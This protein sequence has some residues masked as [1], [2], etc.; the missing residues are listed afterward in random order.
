MATSSTLTK[1]GITWNF[2]NEISYGTYNN[3]DYWVVGPVLVSSISPAFDSRLDGS[4]KNGSM[5]ASVLSLTSQG[6]DE[7]ATFAVPYTSS[8]NA[9]CYIGQ[10][11]PLVV[12][13][14]DRLISVASKDVFPPIDSVGI[15]TCVSSVVDGDHFRPGYTDFTRDYIN[16]SGY[17][18]SIVSRL[19][20]LDI[21][22]ILTKAEPVVSS[23]I[24]SLSSSWFD[25]FIGPNSKLLRPYSLMPHEDT[26]LAAKIS[27]AAA[28]LMLSTG[29]VSDSEKLAIAKYLVQIGI[30]NYSNLKN[31]GSTWADIGPYG[32]GK[33]FP[34]L[35]AGYALNNPDMLSVGT[36]YA[37]EYLGENA[38]SEDSQTFIVSSI[39]GTVNFGYGN[40]QS[41]DVGLPEW[42]ANHW[43]DPTNDSI[44]WVDSTK[45]GIDMRR[46]FTMRNWGGFLLASKILGLQ[47]LWGHNPLFYYFNRYY[48]EELDYLSQVNDGDIKES[49]SPDNMDWH[50]DFISGVNSYYFTDTSRDIVKGV[51]Y[52]GVSTRF[53]CLLYASEFEQ[54]TSSINVYVT[55][56]V[57]PGS[58]ILIVGNSTQGANI[59]T[60]S[61]FYTSNNYGDC[62][63]L[64]NSS[65]P[66]DSYHINLPSNEV[67]IQVY[68]VNASNEA[69][70]TTNALRVNITQEY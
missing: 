30:D 67:Y 24:E 50:Y 7:A 13:P 54:E 68:W 65:T 34:I 3:G 19:P 51:E 8:I 55:N 48:E 23:I 20:K 64:V 16:A 69:I 60:S 45:Y 26:D 15:L 57:I 63:S 21:S 29:Y 42:G 6:F 38:F 47:P 11:T 9:A 40:Y 36:D 1:N 35:F 32:A 27:N 5:L 33:K 66:L 58:G 44:T 53:D 59:G 12:N 62:A 61:I 52:I 41:S 25:P 4:D 46:F 49:L 39:S 28:T 10:Y 56:P 2:A 37:V 18:S 70:A 43:E 22:T 31:L 17:F 14:G